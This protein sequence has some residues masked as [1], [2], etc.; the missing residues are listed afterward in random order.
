MALEYAAIWSRAKY[1]GSK[2][3]ALLSCAAHDLRWWDPHP[4]VH[5]VGNVI[6]R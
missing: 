4:Y 2:A 5:P 1:G 3:A 6:G